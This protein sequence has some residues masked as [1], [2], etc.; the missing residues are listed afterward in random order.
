MNQ[1]KH[2][3]APWIQAE[4]R[5][6][7]T[8]YIASVRTSGDTADIFAP[9]VPHKEY[10]WTR[11]ELDGNRDLILAAPKMFEALLDLRNHFEKGLALAQ[12]RGKCSLYYE[13]RLARVKAVLKEA[14][15]KEPCPCSVC[16]YGGPRA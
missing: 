3:P 16:E 1:Y 13:R 12:K 11:Q 7:G 9:C 14:G 4:Y 6:E 15:W 5:P 2:S 10:V 8:E